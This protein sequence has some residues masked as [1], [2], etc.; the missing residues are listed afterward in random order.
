MHCWPL[1]LK[2]E[3]AKRCLWKSCFL[4]GVV[5]STSASMQAECP[6]WLP[7]ACGALWLSCWYEGAGAL[8]WWESLNAVL[9][10]RPTA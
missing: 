2:A 8:I 3:M 6:L 7:G 10:M 1:T 4:L 5:D 9:E